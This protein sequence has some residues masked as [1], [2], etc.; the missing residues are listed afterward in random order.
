MKDLMNSS[1]AC[2]VLCCS[3]SKLYKLTHTR[4]LRYFK[5]SGRIWFRPDDLKA[6]IENHSIEIKSKEELEREAADLAIG[7]NNHA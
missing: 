6:Y 1:Q 2:N 7:R 3:K 4:E 5:Y